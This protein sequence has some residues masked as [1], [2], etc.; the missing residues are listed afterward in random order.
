VAKP[1]RWLG[2]LPLSLIRQ[3]ARALGLRDFQVVNVLE[4]AAERYAATGS[5]LESVRTFTK[6]PK[7]STPPWR[8][9][10]GA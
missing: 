2:G 3:Q 7:T 1:F 6:V 9:P 10:K 4:R 5:T 8:R